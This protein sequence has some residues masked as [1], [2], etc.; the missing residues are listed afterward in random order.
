MMLPED[1]MIGLL[2]HVAGHGPG[3]AVGIGDD[4]AVLDG[5]LCIATDALVEG[6]HFDRRRLDAA[7]IGARAAAANLSD[8]AAMGAQPVCLLAAFGLPPGFEDV[9]A[10]GAGVASYGVPLAGGDLTRAPVLVVSVTAVGRAERPVLRSGGRPG[11]LLVVTGRLGAQA[12]SGYA[13]RVTPRLTEGAALAETATA[14]LDISDGI[15]EDVRRLARSSG[16]GATVHLGDLPRSPGASVEEAA[17][18][19][20]DYE[21]LAAL[22]PDAGVP[23][24]ATVVGCLTEGPDVLLL[25]DAGVHRDLHG[26]D[27]FR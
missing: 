25:D 23:A 1:A 11:D 27:H 20:E 18:G 14:M 15:A 21:L 7:E 2:A 24:F 3:V 17:C 5:G 16:T 19:G 26:W 9:Q 4:A 10:L 6:V 8:L 22:P 13:S 12:V